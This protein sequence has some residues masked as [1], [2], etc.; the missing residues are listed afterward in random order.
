MRDD[1]RHIHTSLHSTTALMKNC[2][3]ETETTALLAATLKAAIDTL[4]IDFLRQLEYTFIIIYLIQN[5]GTII[6]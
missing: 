4:L 1:P 5:T 3:V 2:W 6:H